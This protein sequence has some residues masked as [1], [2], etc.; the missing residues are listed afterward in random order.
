[1]TGRNNLLVGLRWPTWKTTLL[2]W[3]ELFQLFLRLPVTE[4]SENPQWKSNPVLPQNSLEEPLGGG[5]KGPSMPSKC[6]IL[7]N[8]IFL[9]AEGYVFF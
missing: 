4:P 6:Y 1:M 2:H 7:V 5:G 3:L 9:Y 8:L